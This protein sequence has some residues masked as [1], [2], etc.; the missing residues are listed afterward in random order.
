LNM[1]TS[2]HC[3]IIRRSTMSRMT[4]RN[5]HPLDIA[6]WRTVLR[7]AKTVKGPLWLGWAVAKV[8]PKEDK[9]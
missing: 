7:N 3:Q 6:G 1:K 9:L 8:G 5:K 2:K 4:I